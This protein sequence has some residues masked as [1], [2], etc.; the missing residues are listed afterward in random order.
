M[1]ELFRLLQGPVFLVVMVLLISVCCLCFGVYYLRILEF[2]S[3]ELALPDSV[4][5]V[6]QVVTV[7]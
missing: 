2:W 5:C 4:V 1:T 6:S 7:H 3:A